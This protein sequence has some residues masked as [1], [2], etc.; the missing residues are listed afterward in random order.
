M[1]LKGP[2]L[3]RPPGYLLDHARVSV[4]SNCDHIANLKGP[5]RLQ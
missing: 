5:V 2:N 3:Y 1:I 4:E